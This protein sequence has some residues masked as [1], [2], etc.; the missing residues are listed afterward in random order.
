MVPSILPRQGI[1]PGDGVAL[2]PMAPMPP[3][4]SLQPTGAD[5]SGY[6]GDEWKRGPAEYRPQGRPTRSTAVRR[7]GKRPPPKPPKKPQQTL[8]QTLAAACARRTAEREA[9]DE[10]RDPQPA[11]PTASPPVSPLQQSPSQLLSF[12]RLQSPVGSCS[13][14]SAPEGVPETGES[15]HSDAAKTSPGLPRFDAALRRALNN[16][17]LDDLDAKWQAA[18]GLLERVE[19]LSKA[20]GDKGCSKVLAEASTFLEKGQCQD[21]LQAT[22]SDVSIAGACTSMCVLMDALTAG[23]PELTAVARQTVSR[24]LAAV[25]AAPPVVPPGGRLGGHDSW[26]PFDVFTKS[27]PWCQQ[28]RD[29]TH[30]HRVSRGLLAPPVNS[31]TLQGRQLLAAHGVSSLLE[32]AVAALLAAEPDDAS[33]FLAGYFSGTHSA[34]RLE[35]AESRVVVAD[36]STAYLSRQTCLSTKESKMALTEGVMSPVLVT[37]SRFGAFQNYNPKL[38]HRFSAGSLHRR[39]MYAVQKRL[40]WC[41]LEL[42]GRG[43]PPRGVRNGTRSWDRDLT[44][45]LLY[46]V[47]RIS[48]RTDIEEWAPDDMR[49]VVINAREVDRLSAQD[50][51]DELLLEHHPDTM[52]PKA[53][54][55]YGPGEF[56]ITRREIRRLEESTH[57][58]TS[59]KLT[60]RFFCELARFTSDPSRVWFFSLF[61]SVPLLD[62]GASSTMLSLTRTYNE[63]YEIEARLVSGLLEERGRFAQSVPE[64]DRERSRFFDKLADKDH[65]LHQRRLWRDNAKA[66]LTYLRRSDVQIIASQFHTWLKGVL[67]CPRDY[68]FET[69]QQ[70]QQAAAQSLA[71]LATGMCLSQQGYF[72]VNGA[73][74]CQNQLCPRPPQAITFLS[75]TGIDFNTPSTTVLEAQKYFKPDDGEANGDN[76]QF[77]GWRGFL[78]GAEHRLLERIKHLYITI[79]ASCQLHRVRNPSMLAMGLGAFLM[80][81]HSSDRGRVRE[82]YFKAQFELLAEKDWG[83][84]CYFLNAAQHNQTARE[85]LEQGMKNGAY[86]DPSKGRYLRCSVVIHSRDAKFVAVELSRN[87]MATGVLNPSDCAGLLLGVVGNHWETGR[88][89]YY[90]GEED[91][92]ATSTGLLAHSGISGT[93]T[94][95]GRVQTADAPTQRL[96]QPLRNV[97]KLGALGAHLQ[98]RRASRRVSTVSRSGSIF[99]ADV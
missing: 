40:A 18:A 86:N 12:A 4:R 96:A 32:D 51:D 94:N 26:A 47:P 8:R 54:D 23:V 64:A 55:V 19:A 49:E 22:L 87:N 83:F 38:G 6:T 57:V 92:A 75:A 2:Y 95:I 74:G 90:G 97:D 7:P 56:R 52:G 13:M 25:Y 58:I 16:L 62:V 79:F 37:A 17:E 1:A 53:E 59:G 21:E 10:E 24:V 33:Q 89:G 91:F 15:M 66:Y 44:A 80:N 73:D 42:I 30:E 11:S 34:A 85:M 20:W 48:L 99:A 45:D 68:G 14:V 84:Q 76:A 72:F 78:D 65:E 50:C 27:G 29:R 69:R 81:V 36:E 46:H 93:L 61:R 39:Q 9:E 82:I 60:A 88:C 63:R 28:T 31:S 5:A 67:R 77:T 41:F 3:P 71:E 70:A 43:P 35:V 98:R